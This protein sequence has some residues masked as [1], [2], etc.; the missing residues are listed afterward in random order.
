MTLGEGQRLAN[1]RG[2]GGFSHG[3]GAV[4]AK[5]GRAALPGAT[6]GQI[7]RP[8][9]AAE[10]NAEVVAWSAPDS[11]ET[12]VG[13]AAAFYR[14]EQIMKL[15][16]LGGL[17]VLGYGLMV[18][19]G[20]D[21]PLGVPYGTGG[22]AL[23]GTGG[24]AAGVGGDQTTGDASGGMG[25]ELSSGETSE[26]SSGGSATG[27]QATGGGG[28]GECDPHVHIL[29][30]RTGTM[31][32]YPSLEDNWWTAVAAAL[33]SEEDDLLDEYASQMD[34]S[35]STFFMESGS[36]MCPDGATVEQLE[37]DSLDDFLTEQAADFQAAR[38]AEIKVDG[39]LP[40]AIAASVEQLGSQ[41]D[42]YLLLVITGLPDTCDSA[43][44]QCLS[45][46]ALRAAQAAYQQGVNVRLVYFL[47]QNASTVYPQGLAN[48]GDGQP[49]ADLGFGCGSDFEYSDAPGD[50]DY[51][52]AA[53]TTEVR[54][55]LD[56]MLSKISACE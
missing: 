21:R 48:A 12:L 33:D 23:T 7:L 50:A 28:N 14:G 32:E 37:A 9:G 20:E 36:E 29:L 31:F 42:R 47:D 16:A 39:P 26:E 25:G 53:S 18:G 51:A 43:D 55:A 27:G 24:T 34:L 17:A 19:C 22:A 38:D 5:F 30:Q 11:S 41:G 3:D 49:I 52:S 13:C 40:E 46:D 2:T 15:R 6:R 44:A 56:T 10:D 54:E 35:L 4:V 8:N 1:E 45:E